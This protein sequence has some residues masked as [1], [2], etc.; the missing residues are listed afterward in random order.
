MPRFLEG[1]TH[2]G[3]HGALLRKFSACRRNGLFPA[4]TM[5]NADRGYTAGIDVREKEWR[6]KNTVNP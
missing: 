2:A 6:N 3:R 4:K 1:E 5:Q